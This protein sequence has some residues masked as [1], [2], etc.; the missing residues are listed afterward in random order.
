MNNE[1]EG[2]RYNRF[3]VKVILS[4][5]ASLCVLYLC[6]HSN[7]PDTVYYTLPIY[8]SFQSTKVNKAK[9]ANF[10]CVRNAYGLVP[11]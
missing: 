1:S 6:Y 3:Q 11:G 7:N 2:E 5:A 9:Q 10:Y 8:S 4:Q